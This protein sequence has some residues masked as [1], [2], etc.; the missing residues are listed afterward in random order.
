M[1]VCI[2]NVPVVRQGQRLVWYTCVTQLHTAY[3]SRR[4]TWRAL[5]EFRGALIIKYMMLTNALCSP[6]MLEQS[7]VEDHSTYWETPSA[8]RWPKLPR[9]E[10]EDEN[11][12][13]NPNRGLVE[14]KHEERHRQHR[15]RV[16][17]QPRCHQGQQKARCSG[18]RGA[19]RAQEGMTWK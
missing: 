9:T 4:Q 3:R 7:L 12:T 13:T 16:R 5:C 14:D 2:G 17:Q 1:R 8:Q 6:P 10:P 18:A 19:D 15:R 11:T